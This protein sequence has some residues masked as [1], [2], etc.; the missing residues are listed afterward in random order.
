FVNAAT[1]RLREES[2]SVRQGDYWTIQ[3]HNEIARL[4]GT[5]GLHCLACLLRHPGREFHVSEL[6]GP[7]L[8]V[9]AAVA[10]GHQAA[11]APLHEVGPVFD[12]RAKTQYLRRVAELRQDLEEAQRLNEPERATKAQYEL[13][14]IVGRS[15]GRRVG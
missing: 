4:R 6:I 14:V 1:P 10:A 7:L 8:E 15:E 5:R 9:P 3:Y 12:A 13:D 11:T 2:L